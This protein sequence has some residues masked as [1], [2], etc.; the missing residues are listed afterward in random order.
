MRFLAL[1]LCGILGAGVASL[2][3]S[4]RALADAPASRAPCSA[5]MD[6]PIPVAAQP[7]TDAEAQAY[8]Q[9]EAA[10]PEVQDYAG[11]EVIIGVSVLFLL[12]V[13]VLVLVLLHN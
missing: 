13:L 6:E 4:P 12:L 11:G 1:L 9:R 7:G 8:E 3:G 10:S 2:G 5:A